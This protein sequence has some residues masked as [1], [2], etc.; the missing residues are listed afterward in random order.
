MSKKLTFQEKYLK[1][2]KR[3]KKSTNKHVWIALLILTLFIVGF[4]WLYSPSAPEAEQKEGSTFRASFVGDMMFGRHVTDVRD[5]NGTDYLFENVSPYFQSSDY[6]TGNF[7]NAVTLGEEDAY[8]ET[9]KAILL[10]SNEE[11]IEALK[12]N[13]FTNINL[14][15]NHTMDYGEQGLLDTTASLKQSGLDYVG[16]GEDLGEAEAIDYQEINGMTVATLGVTDVTVPGFRALEFG[17]G[18]AVS[19]LDSVLPRVKEAEENADMVFVHI[20][21]GAEYDN[22]P[23]PRQ[24]EMAHAIVDAGADVIIGHHP[25]VLSPVEVYDDSVIFYSLGNFIFDQGWSRT[26]DS[27]LVQYDLMEDGTGRFE[28]NPMRIREA[29][30]S[31][32]KNPYTQKK[33]FMQLTRGQ[34]DDNY[35]EENGKLVIEVDHSDIL[36]EQKAR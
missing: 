28:I 12:A 16:A 35:T 10:R 17:A 31:L 3:Q 24:E 4:E 6:V 25:H 21:W 14:A 30:P 29:R 5:K 27:A 15:N 23:H 26:R 8:T 33:I 2:L 34:P 22:E 1:T 7:E 18:V 32:T 13:N 9:D 11:P 36:K 19:D 20:H